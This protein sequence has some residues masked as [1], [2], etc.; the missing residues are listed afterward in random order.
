MLYYI[1]LYVILHCM[2][3]IWS[4][5]VQYSYDFIW[6]VLLF[7]YMLY[8]Q[9]YSNMCTPTCI[10]PITKHNQAL[11]TYKSVRKNLQRATDFFGASLATVRVKHII[12]G[13]RRFHRWSV[14]VSIFAKGSINFLV[15]DQPVPFKASLSFRR[16]FFLRAGLVRCQWPK[17]GGPDLWERWTNANVE[18]VSYWLWWTHWWLGK[19]VWRGSWVTHYV[20]H[21]R[22]LAPII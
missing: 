7:V 3:S 5:T 15:E 11:Y 14:S 8:M 16:C 6:L 17:K 10:Q 20:T 22:C 1:N 9:V 2:C 12:S 4:T 21:C 13:F 19:L 18:L